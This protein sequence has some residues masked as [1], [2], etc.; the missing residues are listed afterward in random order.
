MSSEREFSFEEIV[1]FHGKQKRTRC[2]L[3]LTSHTTFTTPKYSTQPDCLM[4][5]SQRKMNHNLMMFIH[6]MFFILL[7]GWFWLLLV[8]H[9]TV[10]AGW[11]WNGIAGTLKFIGNVKIDILS[12]RLNQEIDVT[13]MIYLNFCSP[14]DIQPSSI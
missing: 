4:P 11:S 7:C 5:T 1:P 14:T 6:V 12:T 10:A 3:C 2:A 13:P 9:F 8:Q